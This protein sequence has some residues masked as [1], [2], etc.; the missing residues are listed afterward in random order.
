NFYNNAELNACY[1]LMVSDQD[2]FLTGTPFCHIF[3]VLTVLGPM[4]K[5]AAIV[6]MPRFFP[7]KALELISES[8]VT[9]FA[10]VPTMYIYM[11]QTYS[12]NPQKY[13][14]QAWRF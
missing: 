11:L 1:V 13:D 7:D 6:T 5:G 8:K 2:R 3:F 10:G 14:L 4:Y 12:D 9:H